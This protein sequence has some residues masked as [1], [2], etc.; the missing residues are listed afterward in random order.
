MFA[1]LNVSFPP[2]LF[3]TVPVPVPTIPENVASPAPD[4]AKDVFVP[5]TAPRVSSVPALLTLKVVPD[6][7]KVVAPNVTPAVPD[8]TV[9]SRS[10]VRVCAPIDSVPSVCVTPAPAATRS[11]MIVASPET[12]VFRPN[13]SPVL[14]ASSST[15][16][17]IASTPAPSAPAF[18]V[19]L[20][21]PSFNVVAPVNVFD[22]LNVSNSVPVFVTER[23]PVPRSTIGAV[24]VS[25]P[26]L[27]W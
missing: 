5:V 21:V 2:P 11:D 16:P 22:P 23:A 6:A 15:P 18:P 20:S 7:F 4:T 12:V 1:P 14:F 19:A 13:E 3:A 24:I 26:V 27:Y 10:T 25:P 17:L 8:V 9:A